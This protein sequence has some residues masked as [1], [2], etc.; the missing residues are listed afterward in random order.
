MWPVTGHV[1][2]VIISQA[3]FPFHKLHVHSRAVRRTIT[4]SVPQLLN[5]AR[6]LHHNLLMPP[7]VPVKV[8]HMLSPSLYH[9]KP[10]HHA[11]NFASNA[12]YN[13]Y[14]CRNHCRCATRNCFLFLWRRESRENGCQGDGQFYFHRVEGRQISRCPGICEEC[15]SEW[16]QVLVTFSM[17]LNVFSIMRHWRILC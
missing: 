14:C 6:L 16:P 9:N 17:T 12:V 10:K 3:N 1:T 11:D 13:W 5:M 4:L 2:I 7:A 8:S 15:P